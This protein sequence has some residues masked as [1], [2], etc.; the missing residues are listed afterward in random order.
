MPQKRDIFLPK[1][2]ARGCRCKRGPWIKF[3]SH[4]FP[5]Y[6]PV[7]FYFLRRREV[8]NVMI[9]LRSTF[10]WVVSVECTYRS[11]QS[12]LIVLARW[13]VRWH[14]GGWQ[15]R[16]FPHGKRESRTTTKGTRHGGHGHQEGETVFP[17]S[18]KLV[19]LPWPI[20]EHLIED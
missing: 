14:T 16:W 11:S 18:G 5:Y 12:T 6:I 1:Y 15:R 3:D 20:V 4:Y 13:S 8:A 17:N 10:R 19:K 7:F 9:S 2:T